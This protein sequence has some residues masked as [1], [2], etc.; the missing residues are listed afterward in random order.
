MSGGLEIDQTWVGTHAPHRMSVHSEDYVTAM[1]RLRQ[2]EIGGVSWGDVGLIAECAAA[3]GL[4]GHYL[5]EVLDG[6]GQTVNR[7]GD[8]MHTVA[9]GL[10][11]VEAVLRDDFQNMLGQASI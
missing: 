2:R 9:T 8:D 6:L 5:Q 11:E 1:Q 7:T 4:S 10:D 3:L